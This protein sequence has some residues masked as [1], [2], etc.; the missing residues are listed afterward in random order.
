MDYALL[1]MLVSSGD[2][3]VFSTS[4]VTAFNC[5]GGLGGFLM[6]PADGSKICMFSISNVFGVV[7]WICKVP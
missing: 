1:A 5:Y 2:K 7:R 6:K 3:K 4:I